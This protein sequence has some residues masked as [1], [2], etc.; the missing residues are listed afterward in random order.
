MADSVRMSESQ[1]GARLRADAKGAPKALFQAMFSAAQRG[2]AYLVQ[3]S[4][5]D[6]GLLRNAWKILRLASIKEVQLINDQPYAGVIERGARPFKMS[7]EGIIALTEWVKRKI[8]AGNIQIVKHGVSTRNMPWKK[9]R[10]SQLE[11]KRRGKSWQKAALWAL[12]DEAKKIAHAIAKKFERVGMSGKRFVMKNLHTL[13]GLMDSE[14]KR[15]L[16]KFFNRPLRGGS[17]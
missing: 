10:A 13:A 15:Y 1:V 4:P 6:R 2:K 12:E 8:L 3:R 17:E 9:A 16:S 5:V 11:H 14:V 7:K